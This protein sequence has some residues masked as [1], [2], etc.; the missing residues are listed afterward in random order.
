M[1]E[2][3]TNHASQGE[4]PYA[5]P[6]TLVDVENADINQLANA[7]YAEFYRQDVSAREA[8]ANEAPQPAEQ[9]ENRRQGVL[10]RIGSLAARIGAAGEK[11]QS[12]PTASE[13]ASFAGKVI[14]S[15]TAYEY[16]RLK[17]RAHESWDKHQGKVKMAGA[18]AIG[19]ALSPAILTGGALYLGGKGA[20]EATK[21]TAR[22][23][24]EAI[25][26]TRIEYH[27][28]AAT[29]AASKETRYNARALEI[30]RQNQTKYDNLE[31]KQKAKLQ[32]TAGAS[33][34]KVSRFRNRD[35]VLASQQAEFD[36]LAEKQ[37]KKRAALMSKTTQKVV[38]KLERASQ[39][40]AAAAKHRTKLAQLR[41]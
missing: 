38:P 31:A 20:V 25:K 9:T 26:A 5:N 14:S 40:S 3:Q 37:S 7:A 22:K 1:S 27:E 10:A 34:G 28:R 21:F 4:D 16:N 41:K 30:S 17:T 15:G 24:K 29:A 19:A 36:A 13:Y 8:S 12:G 11:L 35:R 23:S 2:T 6:L 32:E 33:Y 18:I 39:H